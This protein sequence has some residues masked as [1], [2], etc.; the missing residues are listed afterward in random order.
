M[1][2][3]VAVG[4]LTRHVVDELPDGLDG[5]GV[6]V[7]IGDVLVDH[8]RRNGD[9]DL[10]ALALAHDLHVRPEFGVFVSVRPVQSPFGLENDPL[11]LGQRR[12]ADAE[13]RVVGHRNAHF[14]LPE[15]FLQVAAS[16]AEFDVDYDVLADGQLRDV[17]LEV[18]PCRPQ[19]D[20]FGGDRLALVVFGRAA[21]DQQIDRVDD[22]AAAEGGRCLAGDELRLVGVEVQYFADAIQ[23]LAC[24]RP[25][26]ALAMPSQIESGCPIPFRSTISTSWSSTAC[27]SIDSIRMFR[28]LIG[29]PKRSEV[30]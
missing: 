14:V 22:L 21:D 11:G 27:R 12:V 1:H 8:R 6:V 20:G 3:D 23:V 4:V 29:G 2:V 15:D 7:E 10:V 24:E 5:L 30:V 18:L 16:L 9:V 17:F 19:G 28:S 26:D 13:T 25:R